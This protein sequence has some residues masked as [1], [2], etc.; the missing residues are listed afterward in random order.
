MQKVLTPFKVGLVVLLGIVFSIVMIVK[1]TSNW[2]QSDGS[3]MLHA[4]FDDVTGLA[5]RSQVRIAG[6]QIGEVKSIQLIQNRAR[7]DFSIR[8]SVQLFE[9]IPETHDFYKNGVSIGKNLSGILGNYHL[10]LVNG[11]QGR[12][13]EDGD[14]IKNVI[15]SSG[16]EALLTDAGKIMKDVSKVTETLN[17]VFGGDDGRKRFEGMMTD[18]EATI[19]GIREITT[20]NTDKISDILTHIDDIAK[21]FS[22]FSGEGVGK[23]DAL[24]DQITLLSVDTRSLV[25]NLQEKIDNSFD[26]VDSS[27]NSANDSLQKLNRALDNLEKL[28]HNL[29]EGEGSIGKLLKDD[30]IANEAESLLKETRDLIAS[31]KETVDSANTLISPL[32]NLQT[33]ISLREDYMIR[34]NA[35]KTI[36]G[37]KLQPSENKWYL[38][39]LVM[40]PRGTTKTTT[41]LVDS[42]GSTPT[43]ETITETS[44]KIKVSLQ[45]AGRWKFL[46]GR[47][48]LIENTGGVGGDLIF[49][50]DNLKIAL[51]VFDLTTN[52]Y[53][54]LR[55]TALIY[56]NL[57]LPWDWS[58]YLF[59]TGGV[60]DPINT[61]AFDYFVGL[62]FRF[63]DNDL[64]SI[65][66]VM[67]SIK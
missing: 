61:K 8:S 1:F 66:G 14:E 15:Q 37:V 41:R 35:F 64:K 2:G 59:I 25:N 29:Y 24:V 50:N 65:L 56:F 40:D 18:A 28:T 46:V 30:G 5:V 26:S 31:T 20:N 19:R 63:T 62:G 55:A 39:E 49:F 45:F 27:M 53:P 44:D 7:V 58:K 36:F 9:G 52:K 4:Y 17:V 57:F 42:S 3:Y 47:F 54:R 48:G 12:I 43:Y 51:D 16:P 11:L 22:D 60:D 13:L 34:F 23:V 67:P 6:I 32:S 10:E 21:S 33:E 38:L